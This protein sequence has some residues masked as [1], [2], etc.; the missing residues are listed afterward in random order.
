MSIFL[1]EG[2]IS[3]PDEFMLSGSRIQI[4]KSY[5]LSWGGKKTKELSYVILDQDFFDRVIDKPIPIDFRV[6]KIL[7]S[8]P[9]ALD[10]YSWLTYRYS[11]LNKKTSIPWKEL[12]KQLGSEFA[13]SPQG[14]QGFKRATVKAL[15]KIN[16]FWPI[17]AEM[18][19]DFLVLNHQSP[20]VKKISVIPKKVV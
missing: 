12:M 20:H 3:N 8:S 16:T 6:L 11:Y 7:S 14:I 1:H 13:S 9:L 18:N 17:S 10:L 4:A 2:K 15:Q 5:N 19:K